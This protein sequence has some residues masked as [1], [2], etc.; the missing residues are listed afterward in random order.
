MPL[1][2]SLLPPVVL[3]GWEGRQRK[4]LISSAE[5][6]EGESARKTAVREKIA[7]AVH[8][9]VGVHQCRGVVRTPVASGY[10]LAAVSS[11]TNVIPQGETRRE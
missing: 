11:P 3:S 1:Q 2:A 4:G 9:A 8:V 5:V 6:K 7:S 10:E